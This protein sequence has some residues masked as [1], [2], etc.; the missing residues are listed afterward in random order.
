MLY[1]YLRKFRQV[2]FPE[3]LALKLKGRQLD[4]AI[5]QLPEGGDLIDFSSNDYLGLSGSD[6]LAGLTADILR[7]EGGMQNGSTGS[8]L[9]S[10]NHH[11]Y[12]RAEEYLC[13]YYN[14]EAALVFNSGYDANIGFFSSVPQRGDVVLFDELIHASVRDGLSMGLSRSFKFRHNDLDHLKELLAKYVTEGVEVYVVTESVFSMDGDSPDLA[15]M[16]GLCSSMGAFLVVDEAHAVGYLGEQGRGLTYDAGI[17][18]RIFARIITFGK[19]PGVHGA[20]VLG[21]MELKQYL[22]NFARSLIYTTALPPHSLAAIMGSHILMSGG[23]GRAELQERIS[24][25][26]R[27]LQECNPAFEFIGGNSAIISLLLP[28][29]DLVKHAAGY[30]AESGYDVKAILSPTV[31]KGKERLRICLHAYNSLEEIEGLFNRLL[32]FVKPF[33]SDV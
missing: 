23:Q 10:G 16:A 4:N 24:F 7:E 13:N 33:L 15:G 32:I 6:V 1:F 5:R 26:N 25:A 8:R 21:Q 29:N 30:L 14:A 17:R 28:G 22:V 2:E 19:A 31:P 9:I 3:K 18:E 12:K 27:K 20:V 11:L